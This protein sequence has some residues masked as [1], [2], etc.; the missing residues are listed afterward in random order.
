MDLNKDGEYIALG[1]D[2]NEII[3]L[4][5]SSDFTKFEECD[6]KC[7]RESIISDIT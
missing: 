7:Q 2:S 4:R 5:A 6:V 3:I 1:L